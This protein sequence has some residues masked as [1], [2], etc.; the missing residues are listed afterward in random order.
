M[1]GAL[2]LL[3]LLIAGVYFLIQ[4]LKT[5]P[6][7]DARS[8]RKT[9][10]KPEKKPR[11]SWKSPFHRDDS[12]DDEGDGEEDDDDFGEDEEDAEADED[13]KVGDDPS[14]DL[15]PKAGVMNLAVDDDPELA[16]LFGNVD[17]DGAEDEDESES[18]AADEDPEPKA[19]AEA[20]DG[21]SLEFTKDAE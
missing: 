12:Y 11:K 6:R 2:G 20:E 5:R 17:D 16:A 7:D 15:P 14:I 3:S 9:T 1:I 21:T 8:E 4:Y 13:L 10:R 18:D 19:D